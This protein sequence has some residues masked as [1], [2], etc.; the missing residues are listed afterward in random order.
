VRGEKE[1]RDRDS[2]V[3]ARVRRD[4]GEGGKEREIVYKESKKEKLDS[5]RQTDVTEK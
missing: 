2:G 3:K 1:K 5:G 4:N